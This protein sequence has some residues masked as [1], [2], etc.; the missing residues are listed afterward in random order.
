VTHTPEQ[1]AAILR[2]FAD[3]LER[4]QRDLAHG[5]AE[6]VHELAGRRAAGRPSPQAAA[7]GRVLEVRDAVARG[8]ATGRSTVIAYGRGTV[9]L[10]GRP[11]RT[12]DVSFGAEFGSKGTY[13]QFAPRRPDGYFLNPAAQ[14]VTDRAGL[15]WIDRTMD[16]AFSR[17]GRA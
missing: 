11:V 10:S 9:V 14:A 17:F 1:A 7:V 8:K 4:D 6:D 16:A 13:P 2:R 3:L 5:Y 15:S 12:G